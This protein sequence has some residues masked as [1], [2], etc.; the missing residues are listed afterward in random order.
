MPHRSAARLALILIV[1]AGALAPAAHAAYTIP[2]DNPFVGTA[3]ARGEI[4]VYGMRNPFRWSFDRATGDMWLGD[5][6]GSAARNEAVVDEHLA[7]G[8]ISGVNLGWNCLSGNAT[9]GTCFPGHY[10][11]PVYTYPSGADVVIGGYVVR[12]PSLPAF[13]GRYLFGQFNT[14]VRRLES[15]GTATTLVGNSG[16]SGFGEDG[17]GHLHMASLDGH[18]YRL[19][20]NGSGL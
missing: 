1:L 17:A 9:F 7:A 19:T 6:G 14:G 10:V 12:D 8:H 2:P 5:V 4:Y 3:G 16:V 11:G 15:N 13:A 18:V 20:Q